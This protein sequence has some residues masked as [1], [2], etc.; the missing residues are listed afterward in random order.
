MKTF[1]AASAALLLVLAAC[2]G[3]AGD[4]TT[5]GPTTSTTEAPTTTA[6]ETTTTV[7]ETTTTTELPGDPVDFGPRE[8]DGVAVIG[9]AHDDVLNLRA[10][11]GAGQAIL[12]EIPNLYDGLVAQGNTRDLGDSFW[13]EVDYEG[14]VGWVHMS[15]IGYLGV[16]DDL[17]AAVLDQVGDEPLAETMLDIGLIVAETF[18]SDEPAST[19]VLSVAPTV[20]D[21][22]EVTYDVIGIG[23]DSVR[24]FRVHVFGQ[25][26]DETFFIKA[27]EVTTLCGR[28]VT[29]DGLCV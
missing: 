28:G 6:P 5:T 20:G 16:T 21:L 11:P 29:D 27:V 26:E 22:G 7:P 18:A 8:G 2:G 17:T 14:T 24:G 19:I 9:V 1:T 25:P 10:A 3:D 15:F 23:D 13:I 12:A 4:T